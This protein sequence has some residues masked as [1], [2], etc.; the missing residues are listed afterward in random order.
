MAPREDALRHLNSLQCGRCGR[1]FG[2]PYALKRHMKYTKRC[3]RMSKRPIKLRPEIAK[4][5]VK[6]QQ[7]KKGEIYSAIEYCL[8]YFSKY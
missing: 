1:R 5:I 6:L 4:A 2:K 7:A 8:K 3:M